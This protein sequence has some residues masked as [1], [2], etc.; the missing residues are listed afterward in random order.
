MYIRYEIRKCSQAHNIFAGWSWGWVGCTD[1]LQMTGPRSGSSYL[2][3]LMF[4]CAELMCRSSEGRTFFSSGCLLYQ[5]PPQ[6]HTRS[7]LGFD[8]SFMQKLVVRRRR[9]RRQRGKIKLRDSL[10]FEGARGVAAAIARWRLQT[11]TVHLLIRAALI[12]ASHTHQSV[13]A[14]QIFT[15]PAARARSLIYAAHDACEWAPR[16]GADHF[17]PLDWDISSLSAPRQN[18]KCSETLI[19]LWACACALAQ[20]Y[21]ISVHTNSMSKNSKQ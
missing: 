13:A 18:P 19:A 16:Q 15:F 8:C 2:K 21:K 9:R 20:I 7:C 14:P 17:R 5:A 3:K 10:C 12:T 6:Q 1:F 11:M 4:K